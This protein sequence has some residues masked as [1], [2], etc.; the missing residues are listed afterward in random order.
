MKR[1]F[2]FLS[3]PLFFGPVA[4]AQTAAAKIEAAFKLFD[5]DGNGA[6]T[7]EE[8]R[9]APW[10]DRGDENKDGQLTL[11]EAIRRLAALVRRAALFRRRRRVARR[12]PRRLLPRPV[13]RRRL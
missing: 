9:N 6:L 1:L 11:D 10:F 12:R 3:L 8:A 13:A 5:R 2:L 4:R 7:R